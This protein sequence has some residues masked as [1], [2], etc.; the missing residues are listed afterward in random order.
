MA[1]GAS[2]RHYGPQ[3]AWQPIRSNKPGDA[4]EYWKPRACRRRESGYHS[5]SSAVAN[6]LGFHSRQ[7]PSSAY[8]H[9][10]EC[11]ASALIHIILDHGAQIERM[12]RGF[13]NRYFT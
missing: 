11:V 10:A 2:E 8:N 13:R 4:T 9:R 6:N 7:E 12:T 1:E 3:S 5:I